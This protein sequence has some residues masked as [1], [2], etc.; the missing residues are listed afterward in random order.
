MAVF[1]F[2]GKICSLEQEQLLEL[3]CSRKCSQCQPTAKGKDIKKVQFFTVRIGA[4]VRRNTKMNGYLLQTHIHPK[5][6]V[7][8]VNKKAPDRFQSFLRSEEQT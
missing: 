6:Q 7:I 3:K 1:L 5:C 2:M 4:L 8:P